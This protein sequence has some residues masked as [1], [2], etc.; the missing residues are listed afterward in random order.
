MADERGRRAGRPVLVETEETVAR[1]LYKNGVMSITAADAAVP[2]HN[3]AGPGA[4]S[5]FIRYKGHAFCGVF[6]KIYGV[7]P[8]PWQP[9]FVHP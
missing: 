7:S 9:L 1:P 2:Y 6:R 8:D 3:I 5:R 4:F